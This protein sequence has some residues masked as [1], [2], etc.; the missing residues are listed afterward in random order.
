MDASTI[1][2]SLIFALSGVIVGWVLQLLT[3]EMRERR[4]IRRSV[5]MA[6]AACFGRLKKMLMAKQI[7]DDQVFNDEKYNLGHDADRFLQAITHRSKIKQ[8]EMKIY[9][10]IS[11]LLIGV[12]TEESVVDQISKLVE[13]VKQLIIYAA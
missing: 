12:E 11:A 3:S 5:S 2:S 9:E 7:G 13:D 1:L 4:E 10:D 6:A 8:S